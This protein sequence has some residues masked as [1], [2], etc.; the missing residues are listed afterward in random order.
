MADPHFGP[1]VT[2]P[3]TF[4]KEAART[5]IGAHHF[6]SRVV[7]IPAPKSEPTDIRDMKVHDAI[8]YV[9]G[10]TDPQERAALLEMEKQHPKYLGGRRMVLDALAVDEPPA[11]YAVADDG[12]D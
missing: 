5:R 12:E 7:D 6:G 8:A 2:D 3:G 10:V 11:V 4:A 9:E 1:R